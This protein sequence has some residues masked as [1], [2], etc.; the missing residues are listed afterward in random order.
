M[1]K[2]NNNLSELSKQASKALFMAK[3]NFKETKLFVGKSVKKAISFIDSKP[4][5]SFFTILG[6]LLVLIIAGSII[7]KPK[8]A[9]IQKAVIKEVK[10]YKIGSQPT[11]KIQAKIEKSG[12]VKI[13]AQSPGIVNY[14]NVVEGQKVKRGYNLLGLSSNYS[15]ANAFSVQRQI[16]QTTNKNVKE[17]YDIQKDL[18]KKQREAADK[19][20]QNSDQ[21]RDITSK[22]IDETK[23]LLNLNENIS[24]TLNL[25]LTTLESSNQNGQN[26]STI[27]QTKQLI[28]QVSSGINQ[29]KSG[30]RASEYQSASDKPPA[31]LSNI[32][33]EIAIK[34]LELQEKALEMSLTTS[35]LSL[36]LARIQES[37]M[38][39]VAPFDGVIEKVYIVKG[40]SVN[41]GNPLVILH[42]EQKLKAVAQVPKNIAQQIAG[43]SK[44]QVTINGE[45]V[46]II[47]SYV[48]TDA[49]DGQNYSIYFEI[50]DSY[51]NLITDNEFLTFEIPVGVGQD[52][53]L[54]IPID[55]IYKSS[56][57]SY[58]FVIEGGKSVSRKIKV[59]SILGSY[60]SVESGLSKGDVVIVSRNVIN[61]DLVKRID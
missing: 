49:T 48:S 10:T 38:Y 8:P 5:T 3:K 30:L 43:N 7:R 29:L 54:F 52:L 2:Y 58:V 13:V 23:S 14:I 35:N 24:N 59:G 31:E 26:D 19:S 46:E 37:T 16:A 9:P 17:S 15:G 21:L 50:P 57:D 40:K 18:I 44:S 55:S 1:T 6:I 41:P 61:G 4:L 34:Q 60:G 51:Q 56:E 33:R 28:A 39:P 47:P 22:S 25:T 27:L 45:K 20:D 42:G 32:S 12:I 53:D 36:Q 11:I